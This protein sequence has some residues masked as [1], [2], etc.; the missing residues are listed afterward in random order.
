MGR[1]IDPSVKAAWR[2]W[3]TRKRG[4]LMVQTGKPV[5]IGDLAT[6]LGEPRANVEYWLREGGAPETSS[7][8]RVYNFF[9]DPTLFDV[10]RIERPDPVTSLLDAVVTPNAVR[11]LKREHPEQF[12]RLMAEIEAAAA[13]GQGQKSGAAA[14]Y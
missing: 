10:L 12:A 1:R 2:A 3:L 13:N 11:R 5:D 14:S 8:M 9:R 6:L 4:E 7:V